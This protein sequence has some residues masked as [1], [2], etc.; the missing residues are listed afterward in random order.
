[1]GTLIFV[2]GRLLGESV[3][4]FFLDIAILPI[5]RV[6]GS[7]S[8][9][10]EASARILTNHTCSSL[11]LTGPVC[12]SRNGPNLTLNGLPLALHAFFFIRA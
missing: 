1:M 9:K 10:G 11:D 4:E 8:A 3:R 7:A 2:T 5:W 12:R 6:Y